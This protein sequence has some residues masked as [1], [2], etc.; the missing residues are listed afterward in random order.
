MLRPDRSGPTSQADAGQSR[1]PENGTASR[2]SDIGEHGLR[3]RTDAQDEPFLEAG[4]DDGLPGGDR[5]V[6]RTC[7]PELAVDEHVTL[8][9]ER[10]PD[11]AYLPEELLL[12]G[13]RRR[14][15]DLPDLRGGEPEQ[16]R[17]RDG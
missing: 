16:Q 4:H 5:A 8:G 12:A 14:A 9:V 13:L 15:A 10:R 2:D 6:R 17:K 3:R 11:A 1:H 7:A